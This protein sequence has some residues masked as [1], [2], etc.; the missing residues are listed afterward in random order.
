MKCGLVRKLVKEI[1]FLKN[2][3]DKGLCSS[4][5]LN[6]MVNLILFRLFKCCKNPEHSDVK[7]YVKVP[8]MRQNQ[9][10]RERQT[11]PLIHGP[12]SSLKSKKSVTDRYSASI[13]NKV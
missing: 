3:N 4:S 13:S 9:T 1:N 6:S 7:Q 11:L 8:S 10:K 12:S 2:I 5:C